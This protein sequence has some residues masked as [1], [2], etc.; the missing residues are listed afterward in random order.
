MSVHTYDPSQFQL[1]VGGIPL[2]GYADGT[3]I[4]VER[5][6]AM[7]NKVTGADGITS[8]AKTSNKAGQVRVTLAQTSPSNDVM[9]ALAVADELTNAGVFP[10]LL[11]DGS[12]RSV[13]ASSAAWVQ[14]MP[15]AE[16]SKEITNRTWIIDCAG[17]DVF[18]GGN[19]TQ[20]SDS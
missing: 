16:F 3:F 5:D 18:F 8:R 17:M 14:Q 20:G 13:V 12:G 7:W 1:I 6:E 10:V 11:K 4:E 15:T 9:S 19:I 2:S